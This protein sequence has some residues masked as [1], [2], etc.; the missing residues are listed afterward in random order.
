MQSLLFCISNPLV[1]VIFF[2]ISLSI[3]ISLNC[4]RTCSNHLYVCLP[5]ARCAACHTHKKRITFHILEFNTFAPFLFSHPKPI[6]RGTWHV[7]SIYMSRRRRKKKEENESQALD[8]SRFINF[9]VT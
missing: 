6:S 7:I 2:S 5:C 3:L 4:S 1:L 9:R 8:D